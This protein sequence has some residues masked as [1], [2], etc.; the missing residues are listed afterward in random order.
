MLKRRALYVASA[1]ALGML[2]AVLPLFFCP[3]T[4][5]SAFLREIYPLEEAGSWGQTY[6]LEKPFSEN[7][8]QVSTTIAVAVVLGFI[9]WFYA[10]RTI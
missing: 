5:R 7:L 4:E 6:A 1:V 2:V 3:A 10:K 9:S 8:V